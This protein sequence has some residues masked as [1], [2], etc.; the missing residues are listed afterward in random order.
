LVR[1]SNRGCDIVDRVALESMDPIS[2]LR[3]YRFFSL[4]LFRPRLRISLHQDEGLALS[5]NRPNAATVA[6]GN[7]DVAEQ[8][9]QT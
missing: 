4:N 7:G 6:S 8:S 1:S 2:K 9:R 3:H 5:A